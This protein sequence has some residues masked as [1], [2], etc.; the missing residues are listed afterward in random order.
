MAILGF[1]GSRPI[2]PILGGVAKEYGYERNF[3]H[4]F[5]QNG[6]TTNYRSFSESTQQQGN[7]TTLD[8]FTKIIGNQTIEKMLLRVT[9][10][11]NLNT[12]SID[13]RHSS[14]LVA[15]ETQTTL[16]SIPTLATG[17]Y[18]ITPDESMNDEEYY[19]TRGS[20]SGSGQLIAQFM[21][22]IQVL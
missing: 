9:S 5:L 22:R 6:T 14:D 11:A 10:N 1:Q 17:N 18:I 15:W 21:Y 4:P 19:L 20:S 7:E 13:L 16:F 2:I 8:D 12:T 3:Q